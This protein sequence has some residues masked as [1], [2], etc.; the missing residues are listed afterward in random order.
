MSHIVIRGLSGLKCFS[1]LSHKRHNFRKKF[2]FYVKYVFRFSL[3]GLFG[4]FL[5]VRR[6]ERGMIKN[7]YLP[8][9][10][11]FVLMKLKLS[12]PIF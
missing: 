9:R 6:T 2:F 12:R 7:V 5:I 10:R 4:T 11:V 3:Q 8:S 1:A